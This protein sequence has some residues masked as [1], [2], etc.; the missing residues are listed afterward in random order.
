MTIYEWKKL[1]AGDAVWI[2][3]RYFCY[4][5]LGVIKYKSNKKIV[6]LNM[7]GDAQC[8]WSGGYFEKRLDCIM[9]FR[10]NVSASD[11]LN[12]LKSRRCDNCRFRVRHKNDPIHWCTKRQHHRDESDNCMYWK[13]A[14]TRKTPIKT[15]NE[16]IHANET[17]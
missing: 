16:P 3:S 9:P 12:E 11:I 6:W 15:E 7:F 10:Q 4:P 17:S 1:K 5:M 8:E 2:F 14:K 13:A